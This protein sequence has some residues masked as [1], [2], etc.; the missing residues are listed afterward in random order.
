MNN[1]AVS[2]DETD[3][4]DLYMCRHAIGIAAAAVPLQVDASSV[5][6][7]MTWNNHNGDPTES[8]THVYLA[9]KFVIE[10]LDRSQT[11]M[12]HQEIEWS[13]GEHSHY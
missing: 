10:S 4:R 2:G 12:V 8:T 7:V 11:A 3:C 9:T 6:T 1:N 13:F 5:I